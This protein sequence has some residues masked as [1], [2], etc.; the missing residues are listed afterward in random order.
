M[1][2][3]KALMTLML[4]IFLTH[5]IQAQDII[6]IP[7]DS[8]IL[9]ISSGVEIAIDQEGLLT[10]EDVASG[11]FAFKSTRFPFGGGYTSDT[12]WFR[13][14]LQK[15]SKG[16]KSILLSAGPTYIDSLVLYS[17]S[18][19]NA[20]SYTIQTAGDTIEANK[21]PLGLQYG[22]YTFSINLNDNNPHT[23][24]LK[25][26]GY[27]D[28]A[29]QLTLSSSDQLTKIN[30]IDLII[31]GFII[32]A[33]TLISIN[34]FIMWRWLKHP[35]YLI[36]IGY[37]LFT[38]THKI[39]LS[40]VIARY[41][42][43]NSPNIMNMID[44]LSSSFQCFFSIIFY[45]M[46]YNSKE[47]FSK[48]HYL[49]I[50][51]LL[52]T[53][54]TLISIPL[55]YFIYF[56]PYMLLFALFLLPS[57]LFI[58]WK[59]TRTGFMGSKAIFIGTS[60]YVA[61]ISIAILNAVGIVPFY[62]FILNAPTVA[63]L[64]FLFSMQQGMYR[65]VNQFEVEKIAAE[66]AANEANKKADEEKTRRAEQSTFMTMVAHEIHTPLAVIDSAIQTIGINN[67]NLAPFISDRHKRIQN[68]ISLLNQLLENTLA[69]ESNES[70]PLQPKV[71]NINTEEFVSLHAK[72]SLSKE[73]IYTLDIEP[74]SIITADP[75]LLKHIISNL[76]VNAEKYSPKET[77]IFI[78]VEKQERKNQL[79]IAISVK[80][81]HFSDK[82]IEP[83]HWLKKYF[84]QTDTP[85][86][87]GFGLGLYLVKKITEAHQGDIS[88]DI[89]P[90]YSRFNW[91]VTIS[92]WLPNIRIEDHI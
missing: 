85:N 51:F 7:D 52:L 86:I 66:I 56:A 60:I 29:L 3:L 54:L 92:V 90:T 19:K 55:G 65:Q 62:P 71:E 89:Q 25:M 13:F 27:D 58:S 67:P 87:N 81:S 1:A 79:G 30:N 21:L 28:S 63:S 15:K 24:Y 59:A 44:P 75:K 33:L 11:D 42:L 41:L 14:T 22:P 47:K 40:G 70:R 12:F 36:I 23:F 16:K 73:K 84:R 38:I 9:Y 83:S 82:M 35:I 74:D 4:G 72:N 45:I 6:Q 76:L 80:N 2:I 61:L 68:S 57:L 46:Y 26:H 43:P 77:P 78:T 32:G 49:F 17:P 31:S 5:Q 8:E 91:L 88:I 50:S 10:L 53:I 37:A 20:T 18:T 34:A 69:A 64:I 39:M 48:L